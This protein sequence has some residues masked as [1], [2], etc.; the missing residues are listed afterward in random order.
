MLFIVN[1]LDAGSYIVRL[2]YVVYFMVAGLLCVAYYIFIHDFLS[3]SAS[4][5]R[6]LKNSLL[7]IGIQVLLICLIHLG[8]LLYGYF[9]V[10]NFSVLIII[11]EGLVAAVMLFGALRKKKLITKNI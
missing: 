1:T 7:A 4:K 2:V 3:T 6:L 5:G 9:P 10:D 8:L 11:L